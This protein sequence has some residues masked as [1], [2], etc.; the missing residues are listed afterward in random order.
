MATLVQTLI[1]K[2]NA[3]SVLVNSMMTNAKKIEDLPDS[4]LPLSGTSYFHVS[5]AGVSG[6]V[7]STDIVAATIEAYPYQTP[8]IWKASGNVG[9]GLEAGD[10]VERWWSPTEFWGLARYDGGGDT[11]KD[12]YTRITYFEDL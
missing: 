3:L 2:V 9:V 12:N 10:M 6:K 8:T 1:S 7:A 4:S 11:V 5:Q